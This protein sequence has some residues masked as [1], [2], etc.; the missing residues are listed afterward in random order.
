MN[1][2]KTK[3]I[4]LPLEIFYSNC[5]ECLLPHTVSFRPKA[6]DVVSRA[7]FSMNGNDD[8]HRLVAEKIVR[9]WN[10]ESQRA[11]AEMREKAGLAV[12]DEVELNMSLISL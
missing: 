3:D 12:I 8:F 6:G 4:A 2:K 9:L 7:L 1:H 5:D 11:E 10:E